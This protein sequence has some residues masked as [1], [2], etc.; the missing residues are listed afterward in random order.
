MLNAL[1]HLIEDNHYRVFC[2]LIGW[3]TAPVIRA[4]LPR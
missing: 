1:R 4:L 3:L 2:F